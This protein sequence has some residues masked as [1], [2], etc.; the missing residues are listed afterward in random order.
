MQ[1]KGFSNLFSFFFNHLVD[2]GAS[3]CKL[4][5]SIFISS[6]NTESGDKT[7]EGQSISEEKM[8]ILPSGQKKRSSKSSMLQKRQ[9][10][11]E[12]GIN[13]ENKKYTQGNKLCREF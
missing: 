11:A 7:N 9:T 4:P 2:K 12:A 8:R 3:Q 10:Q 1:G 5:N 6:I 13:C